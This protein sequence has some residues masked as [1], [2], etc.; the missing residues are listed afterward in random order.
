MDLKNYNPIKKTNITSERQLILKDF[1]DTLNIYRKPPY[2][3]LTPAR[4]GN[5]MR[6]M[7]ISQMKQFY[8][9]CKQANHF[10]KYFWWKFKGN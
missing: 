7:T 3:P 2:K 10:S 9:E 5:M 6:F 1:L 8:S 4:L